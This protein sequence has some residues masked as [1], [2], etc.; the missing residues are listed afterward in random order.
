MYIQ[1]K[2]TKK[3]R[4]KTQ[5]DMRLACSANFSTEGRGKKSSK[6]SKCAVSIFDDIEFYQ[7]RKCMGAPSKRLKKARQRKQ[8]KRRWSKV[9]IT[10]TI[11]TRIWGSDQVPALRRNENKTW[12]FSCRMKGENLVEVENLTEY[13]INKWQHGKCFVRYLHTCSCMR[14]L[15]R[16]YRKRALSMK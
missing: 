8:I 10:K 12:Y 15:V 2:Q 6:E 1:E 11:Y 5:R 4:T 3:T 16:K 9:N 13:K 14:K 7:A